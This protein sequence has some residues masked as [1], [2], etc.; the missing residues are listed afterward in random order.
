M[1]RNEIDLGPIDYIAIEQKARQLRAKALADGVASLRKWLT[2]RAAP[3][4]RTA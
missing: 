1:D 2:R 4:G 3:Q